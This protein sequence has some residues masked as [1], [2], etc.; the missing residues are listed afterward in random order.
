M[1][2][3]IT[4]GNGQLG[5][6]LVAALAVAAGV[7]LVAGCGGGDDG[8]EPRLVPSA[9]E[10]VSFSEDQIQQWAEQLIASGGAP[11]R[12]PSGAN[13]GVIQKPASAVGFDTGSDIPVEAQEAVAQRAR[14][15][16][17]LVSRLRSNRCTRP[18]ES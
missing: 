6:A 7:L 17:T 3:L 15:F 8:D 18:C 4:G 2:V 5:R 14:C 9:S 13:M 16:E 1:Q 10:P 11:V 12:C